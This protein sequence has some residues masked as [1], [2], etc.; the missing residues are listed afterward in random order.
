MPLPCLAS[1]PCYPNN[2]TD[3]S[4]VG[5]TIAIVEMDIG[6][7]AASL[8]VMR[9]C[10]EAARNAVLKRHS[11]NKIS[12]AQDSY[13]NTSSRISGQERERGIVRTID[14]EL[15]SQPVHTER[16]VPKIA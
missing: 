11:F 10:F 14:L 5:L 3:T 16:F 13:Y 4:I 1:S 7:I 15:E 9:P 8:V 2:P 12:S 6:I